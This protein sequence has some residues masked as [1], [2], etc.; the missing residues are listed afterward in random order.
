[1]GQSL[2]KSASALEE[3]MDHFHARGWLRIRGAFSADQAAAMR[4]IVWRA[5]PA[6]GVR[7]DDPRT[8]RTDRPTHLQHLKSD[9]AFRS[10]G[11]ERTLAAVDKVL[12]GRPWRKPRDW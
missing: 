7:R 9:P 5:L 10:V 2:G 1:M 6:Q 11:S 4:D 3:S 12:A 8:W